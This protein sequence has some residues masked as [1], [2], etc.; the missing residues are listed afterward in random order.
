MGLKYKTFLGVPCLPMP[1]VVAVLFPSDLAS[2]ANRK[3]G[4]LVRWNTHCAMRAPGLWML[5]VSSWLSPSPWAAETLV[6]AGRASPAAPWGEAADAGDS[7]KL[8]SSRDTTQHVGGW[9]GWGAWSIL[10]G[11]H[12]QRALWD[13]PQ[14]KAAGGFGI[15]AAGAEG[16]RGWAQLVCC[17]ALPN[18]IS[19]GC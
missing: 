19:S 2:A 9:A 11:S 4:G 5:C 8:L 6:C 10:V 12:L 13:K 1:K 17:P 18:C 15:R 16:L 7:C 14:R 3:P